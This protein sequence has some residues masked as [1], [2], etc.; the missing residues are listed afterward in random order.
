[1]SFSARYDTFISLER[2]VR[3]HKIPEFRQRRLGMKAKRARVSWVALVLIGATLALQS[4]A[5]GPSKAGDVSEARLAAE[6][7]DVRG[8]ALQPAQGNHRS[9]RWQAW[10]DLVSG[11]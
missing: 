10:F 4:L 9:E 1:M 2:Q 7:A 11:C 6:W 8:T 3:C 5:D